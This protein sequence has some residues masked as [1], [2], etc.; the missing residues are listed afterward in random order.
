MIFRAAERER[1]EQEFPALI[2]QD[3]GPAAST[4]KEARDEGQELQ[5]GPV[6]GTWQQLLQS[7]AE[8]KARRRAEET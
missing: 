2:K 6:T 3:S 4:F 7:S 5:A 8:T 1:L